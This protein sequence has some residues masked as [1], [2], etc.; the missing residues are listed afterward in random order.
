MGYYLRNT[1]ICFF[2]SEYLGLHL[3]WASGGKKYRKKMLKTSIVKVE[4]PNPA[5]GGQSDQPLLQLK[6]APVIRAT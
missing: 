1:M 6:F 3:L 2:L 4:N 5:G